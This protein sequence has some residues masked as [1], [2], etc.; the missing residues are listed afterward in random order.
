MLITFVIFYDCV[1][2]L[3]NL[4]GRG[5]ALFIP[6]VIGILFKKF[7][8]NNIKQ[9]LGNTFRIFKSVDTAIFVWNYF[10]QLND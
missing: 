3:L 4:I 10:K 6:D 5:N 8:F 7:V 9:H 1:Y 2:L